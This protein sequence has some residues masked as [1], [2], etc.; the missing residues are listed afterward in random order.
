MSITLDL[1]LVDPNNFIIRP[2]QIGG[3]DCIFTCPCPNFF[4]WTSDVLHFRSSIWNSS[5]KLISGSYKKFFNFEEKP[6]ITPF[7]DKFGLNAYDKVD[8]S[9]LIISYYNGELI[10]RTRGATNLSNIANQHEL[11]G[12]KVRYSEFFLNLPNLGNK[13]FLF[14]WTSPI[15]KIVLDYG[16]A[17]E[18]YLTSIINNNDYSLETQISVDEFAKQF[19][20]KRPVKFDINNLKDFIELIKDRKDIEGIC[21]YYN[22]DQNIRKVKSLYYL[23]LHSFR[24][25]LNLK[26][27]VNLYVEWD[28][29]TEIELLTKIEKEFDYECASISK[30]LTSL[31]YTYIGTLQNQIKQVELFVKENSDLTQKDFAVK[32]QQTFPLELCGFG[33][34]FRKNL[35]I[36]KDSIRKLLQSRIVSFE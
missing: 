28:Y 9:T 24:S 4:D 23:K 21:L 3:E 34:S 35:S 13:T 19:N 31:L 29:P 36:N 10:T 8:G 17:P 27:L 32:I 14:E 26:N 16:R 2:V 22:N 1:N 5:G 30:D 33:F 12:F 6:S 25:Q 18:I 15:N 11:E 7:T 20:L